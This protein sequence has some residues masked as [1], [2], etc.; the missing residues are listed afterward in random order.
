MPNQL[1]DVIITKVYEGKSDVGKFGPWT[2]Y[3]FYVEGE[4]KKFSWFG[5]GDKITPVEGMQIAYMEYKTEIE[6]KYTNHKVSKLTIKE[7]VAQ[8]TPSSAPPTLPGKAPNGREASFYVAYMK[9]IA[10][11]IINCGGGLEQTD[12]D[13]IARKVAQA[14]LVMMNES[15]GNAVISSEEPK[16]PPS[17]NDKP[18]PKGEPPIDKANDPRKDMVTCEVVNKDG[19]PRH[20]KPVAAIYCLSS[21]METAHCN[22]ARDLREK[23]PGHELG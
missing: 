17:V 9:D 6:G 3:N 22:M 23:Y 7:G 21:C 8:P 15:L 20:E 13:T 2:A 18:K 10:V 5:G 14:G 16:I 12:L 11:A 19:T 4:D 1:T